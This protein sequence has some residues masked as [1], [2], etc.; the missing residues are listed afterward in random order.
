MGPRLP[1]IIV[2][3][4]S[5]RIISEVKAEIGRDQHFSRF[6][7]GSAL[8]FGIRL[9]GAVLSYL[10]QVFIA[11]FLGAFDFGLYS[12]A[13]S[14][15]F[16]LS[17]P[18]TM[19]LDQVLLRYYP[20][21]MVQA[22]FAKAAGLLR[23]AVAIVSLSSLSIIAVASMVTVFLAVG[24]ASHFARP[25]LVSLGAILP[26]TLLMVG[27]SCG[28][29][30]HTPML[31]LVPHELA[32]HILLLAAIGALAMTDVERSASTVLFVV[33]M[34]LSIPVAGQVAGLIRCLPPQVRTARPQYEGYQWVWLALPIVIMGVFV[35]IMDRSDVLMVGMFLSPKEV[36]VYNAASR[37]ATIVQFAMVAFL[38]FTVPTFSSL[39]AAGKREELKLFVARVFQ[40]TLWVT[41]L[42]AI[43]L[44]VLSERIMGLFGPGFT[45]GIV[46][47]VV[48]IVAQFF[49]SIQGPAFQLLLVTGHQGITFLIYGVSAAWHILLNAIFIPAFGIEGAAAGT[50]TAWI[51]STVWINKAV[52]RRL[53]M[54]A[55]AVSGSC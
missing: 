20:A 40:W 50:A 3:N 27:R 12:F 55:F 19:G 16:L 22:D 7:Q 35:Q 45:E 34:S 42:V 54:R 48:L 41:V 47:F 37:T 31:A 23:F 5:P 9:S 2:M 39:H 49:L 18:A 21:Y 29:A 38:A 53:N 28:R 36:A 26:L 24:D 33:L 43:T 8:A 14:C 11:R 44:I 46:A 13:W 1:K 25:M 6:I 17:V 10:T 15:A 51:V 32:F 4:P 30:M 52:Q